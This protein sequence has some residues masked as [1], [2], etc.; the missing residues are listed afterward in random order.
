[1]R[2]P[3]ADALPSPA[4][5]SAAPDRLAVE[6]EARV[7]IGDEEATR[8]RD[9]DDVARAAD[10]PRQ[11]RRDLE[12]VPQLK[13]AR[14]VPDDDRAAGKGRERRAELPGFERDGAAAAGRRG[15]GSSDELAVFFAIRG[16][17]GGGFFVLGGSSGE[18]RLRANRG[19]PHRR[20][21]V[22]P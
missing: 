19:V 9:V 22:G 10:A 14:E 3:L 15:P 21:G 2:I 18:E 20:L 8:R 17:E 16:R 13:L 5:A 6:R 1:M 12:R 7:A 4:S 11:R